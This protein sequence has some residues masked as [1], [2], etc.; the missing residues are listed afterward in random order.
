M[1]TTKGTTMNKKQIHRA[2]H[3]MTELHKIAPDTVTPRE[4]SH[5]CATYGV[6]T[7]RFQRIAKREQNFRPINLAQ[8]A[9][10]IAKKEGGAK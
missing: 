10:E 7:N 5:L 3:I 6:T 2:L 9:V 8:V 4:A 1:T